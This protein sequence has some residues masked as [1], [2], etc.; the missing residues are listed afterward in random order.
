MPYSGCSVLHG[1]NTN[2]KNQKYTKEVIKDNIMF[3]KIA[4]I[5]YLHMQNS[6]EWL[7]CFMIYFMIS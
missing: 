3:L 5:P 7:L 1:V 4:N 2:L 6:Q